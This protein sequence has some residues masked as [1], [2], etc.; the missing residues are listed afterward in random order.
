VRM[1]FFD[2][3]GCED[4]VTYKCRLYDEKFL[5]GCKGSRFSRGVMGKL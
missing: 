2:E 4:Y 5:H 3:G 1:K